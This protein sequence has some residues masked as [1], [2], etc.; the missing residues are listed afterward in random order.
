MPRFRNMLSEGLQKRGYEVEV[1]SPNAYFFNL[2]V[3]A[4]L[5]KWMGYIDQFI[6]FPA[7][8][9]KR[10]KNQYDTLYVFADHALGMWVPIVKHLPH[11]II[12]HD[13]LAQLSAKGLI[14]QNPTGWSGRIYQQLIRNGYA[15]G[16]N[17]ISVS[18]KT[19]Q[20]LHGF[21]GYVPALSQVVYNGLNKPFVPVNIEAA[22]QC[23][24]EKTG[25]NM[26]DGY[27]LHV[28]GNQWYKNRIGVVKIY[29]EWRARYDK[30]LPLLL[31]GSPPSP[32]LQ[33]EIEMSPYK[34][35]IYLL[36]NIG[37]E[38]I[39]AA[40]SGAT[41][42]LF[43]SLGEGFGWPIAEAMASG[44]VVITT[45]AAPMTEVGGDAAVY[46]PVQPANENETN[47]W[48]MGA[49]EI[50]NGVI[51]LPDNDHLKLIAKG[52]DNS[53]RFDTGTALDKIEK[54]LLE[55]K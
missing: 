27:I 52:L 48:A 12:C 22:R 7:I 3:P 8:V 5:K 21:L 26:L 53:K 49:A 44:C 34:S 36:T 41:V 38:Y 35:Q 6:I 29:N 42:L 37:D 17:F 14:S 4:F 31:I 47:E 24:N 25:V 55:L 43:P 15:K 32:N 23:I 40:Y 33:Q 39:N 18:K 45:N 20:D 2:P 30:D 46:I 28:G 16:V 54:I 51:S 19:Q 9:K 13:F 50:L 11:A 10:I 1:Y